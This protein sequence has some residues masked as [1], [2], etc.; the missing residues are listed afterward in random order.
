[1]P[2]GQYGVVLLGLQ[3][4]LCI[5]SYKFCMFII[6]VRW[7]VFCSYMLLYF[8]GYSM[9]CVFCH[10]NFACLSYTCSDRFLQLHVA[11]YVTESLVLLCICNTHVVYFVLALVCIFPLGSRYVLLLGMR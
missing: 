7:Q 9:C 6:H 11:L 10:T 8:Y 1:M 2:D 3:Y 5:L 4:V